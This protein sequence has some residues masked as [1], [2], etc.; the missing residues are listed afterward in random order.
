MNR[1]SKRSPA[2]EP[3][4]C[5]LLSMSDW[6]SVTRLFMTVPFLYDNQERQSTECFLNMTQHIHYI[7]WKKKWNLLK[8][9]YITLQTNMPGFAWH[10]KRWWNISSKTFHLLNQW[11]KWVDSRKKASVFENNWWVLV[12]KML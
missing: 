7:D 3:P 2:D 9:D 12:P 11:Q 1:Q 4:K 10:I 8:H 6:S 5:R